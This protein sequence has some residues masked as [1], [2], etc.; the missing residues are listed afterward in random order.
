MSTVAVV[1][2]G[3]VGMT[4]ALSLARYGVPSVLLDEDEQ[5]TCVG[6][7]SICV[8]RATLEAFDRLG[9]G[10]RM[11]E[12]GVTWTCGRTYYRNTELFQ[13]RFPERGSERFPAFVNLSQERVERI[14]L[15]RVEA[16]PL[17][18]LRWRSR[19]VGVHDDAD[20]VA[21]ELE[22]G[23]DVSAPYAVA[24]DGPHSTMR[25]LCRLDFPGHGHRDRFLI[26]DIQ[27]R[28]PFPSERRFFF[29][30]PS[31][32]G[33]QVLL[34]PQPDDVWRID[35]QVPPEVDAEEE[36][37]SGRLDERIRAIVGDT[38]YE[39]VWLTGYTFHQRMLRSFRSGRVFFAG[40]AAH[41]MAPFG[42]RGMNSGVQDA[43][44]LAWKLWGV[45]E[46][47]APEALLDTYDGER[48]AAAAHNLRVVDETMRFMVPPTR[49][50]RLLRNAILRASQYVRPVRRLVNS[51]RLSEPFVYR[52]SPIVA[53]GGERLDVRGRGFVALVGQEVELPR[54]QVP[55]ELRHEG[56]GLVLVRPD[57]HVAAR[58]PDATRLPELLELAVAA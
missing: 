20:G 40:D 19:V 31:N 51:G 3:P 33:R 9:V 16:E 38:P 29:D 37:E 55:L 24:C 42:A 41:V 46:G 47:W 58:T 34:H 35:W 18:E 6:S 15:E 49:A 21:L 1:G 14:L 22:G 11:A 28:L 39:L 30:P 5:T 25:K 13:I 7:R 2:A 17:V 36:R 52:G 53:D 26:A 44:N 56:D 48:R 32:R 8:Q 27:A 54:T 4:M 43:E 23:D 10:E 12:E 50:R 45:L 57:G